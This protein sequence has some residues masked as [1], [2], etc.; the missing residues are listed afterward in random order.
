MSDALSALARR[1]GHYGGHGINHHDEPFYGELF[2][3]ELFDGSG[4]SIRF[5]ALG[6]DGTLLH[7][8]RTWIATSPD[9]ELALWTISTN[10]GTVLRHDLTADRD[11]E[12]MERVL[13]FRLGEPSDRSILRN[14]VTL[15]LFADGRLG[16]RYAWGRPGEAFAD[17]SSVAMSLVPETEAR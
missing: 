17:R 14:Q 1:I 8:E 15:E 3:E 16:Y 9:G 2:L 12:D 4:L 13:V 6:I 11:A 7:D 10:A 5:T